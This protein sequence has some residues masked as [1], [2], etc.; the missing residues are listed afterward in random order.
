MIYVLFHGFSSSNDSYFL[1]TISNDLKTL[2]HTVLSPSLSRSEEPI[3]DN[4]IMESMDSIG[5]RKN[6]DCIVAHSLG[7]LLALQLL[8]QNKIK[9]NKLVLIGSSFGPKTL[10]EMN[11]FLY[12]PINIEKIKNNAENIYSVFSFDDPWTEPEY[13]ILQVKQLNATGITYSNKGH[14]EDKDLPDEVRNIIGIF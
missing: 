2:G 8:S 1:P 12:P 6:L 14:F 9:S 7:G 13:G 4:W 5:N 10:P 11:N 3:L